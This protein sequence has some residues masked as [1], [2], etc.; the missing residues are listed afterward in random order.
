MRRINSPY[1]ARF[2]T[3][4]TYRRLPLFEEVWIRDAFVEQL[5]LTRVRHPLSL[6]AWVLMPEHVHLLL[7]ERATGRLDGVLKTLKIGLAKR[8]LSVWRSERSVVLDSILDD[9]GRQRFWQR[10]GGYDRNIFTS[11]EFAEKFRYI[12]LNPVRRGLV[13]FP[14]EWKWGSARW[15]AGRREGEIECDYY[16]R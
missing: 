14:E 7:H 9:A 11:E 6:Y 3:F 16:G 5:R 13:K 8:V 2:L 12:H 4:S 15:W 10:G 1:H